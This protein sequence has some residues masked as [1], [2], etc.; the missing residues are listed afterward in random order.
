MSAR[1][2]DLPQ[3]QRFLTVEFAYGNPEVFERYTDALRDVMTTDGEF[4]STPEIEVKIG[5]NSAT[6]DEQPAKIAIPNDDFTES[7]SLGLP[8]APIRVTI[9]EITK[10]IK[11]SDASSQLVLF[12]G[13]VTRSFRGFEGRIDKIM[14][15]CLPIKS[16]LSYPVG[17]PA[18]HH[19]VFTLFGPGCG[20]AFESNNGTVDSING[21]VVTISGLPPKTGKHWHRGYI[22]YNN[23]RVG[24]HDW[25]AADPTT[26]YLRGEVPDSLLNQ[27]IQVIPGCDK[28]I[29]TCRSRW[30]NESNFGGFGFGV[31][32]YHPVYEDQG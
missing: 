12:R 13:R 1:A 9:K 32:S 20:L 31:P 28:T 27:S 8:F 17:V 4:F 15:E 26:F 16:R 23:T 10:G 3:K 2:I 18:N 11:G 7:I 6:F 5:R 24:I 29:E 19:C 21:K 14:L 30:N 22:Q 25:D